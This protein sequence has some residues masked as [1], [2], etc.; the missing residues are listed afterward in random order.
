MSEFDCIIQIETVKNVQ[1]IKGGERMLLEERLDEIVKIVN[2]RGSISNQELVKMFGASESTIRRDITTLAN[3]NRVIRVHGGAMSVVSGGGMEDSEVSARRIQNSEGDLV[4]IDAGTTT[5]YMIEYITAKDATFVTNALSHAVGLARKGFKVYIIGGLIKSVTE[6]IIDSEAIISLSKYNFT[7]GFFG[8]NGLSSD[9]GFTTPDV[10][11]ADI[12]NFAMRRC[13]K[14][15]VLCDSS[16]FNK[17]SKATFA[18]GSDITVISDKITE[19][20]KGYN[21][22]EA[23]QL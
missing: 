8:T 23:A 11:E 10:R 4:Y 20:I 21:I 13:A 7:K 5:E 9:R 15:F 22:K 3:D 16:K 1:T 19:N 14:K 6:A 2:E 18:A 17:I 12:K